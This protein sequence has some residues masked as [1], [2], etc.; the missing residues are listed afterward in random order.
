[1]SLARPLAVMAISLCI[2]SCDGQPGP[3]GEPGPPGSPGP[4]GDVGPSGV[5][6]PPGPP[7]LP[8]PAGPPGPASQARVIREA[9]GAT[10]CNAQCNID[11]VLVTAYCG[12]GR[13]PAKFLSENSVSCGVTPSTQDS[14]L[15]VVCVRSQGQ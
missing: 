11:E 6:G 10:A 9:C 5:A 2:A 1:M 4:R 15:V 12:A 14:P 8:G 7:G 3:K 13:K